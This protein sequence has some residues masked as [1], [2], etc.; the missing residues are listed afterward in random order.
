[1]RPIVVLR[2]EPGASATAERAR[3]LGLDVRCV[4]LFD[5]ESIPWEAPEPGRFDGLLLTSANAVRR[6]GEALQ[7]L[8]GLKVYAVGEA[9]AAEARAA[10][11]DVASSGEAGVDRL[12]GSLEPE[13][14]LLHLAGEDRTP[15]G[16]PAQ[17]ITAIAI[18]RAKP[19][20]APDLGELDGAVVL[21]HSPRA[22]RRMAELARTRGRTAIAA[23][24]SAAAEAA[25]DGWETVEAAERPTDEALLALAARLC[26][27]PAP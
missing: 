23:I 19:V 8:R 21:V 10:G 20:E 12:L 25:G 14:R 5:V 6:G 15:T 22:G 24:S 13:L 18:Y 1:M 27:K 9:T 3:R 11:F 16:A 26:N 4:P 7:R 2:P 17:D